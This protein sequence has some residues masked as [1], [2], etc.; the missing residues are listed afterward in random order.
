MIKRS[1]CLLLITVFL[2]SSCSKSE[3]LAGK[4]YNIAYTPVL[5]EDIDQPTAYDSLIK[6]RFSED[7]TVT[8]TTSKL[9]GN[10]ELKNNQLLLRFNNEKESLVIDISL[11]ESDF[12]FS[13]YSALIT[14]V[15]YEIENEDELAHL[16]EL[17][18]DV[19]KDRPM[20]LIIE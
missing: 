19:Q 3:N 8:D 13:E 12:D 14:D 5:E 11:E 4:Q 1:L 16:K 20:E 6:L 7:N 10:Y 9:D 18:F 15:K 2:I 17:F